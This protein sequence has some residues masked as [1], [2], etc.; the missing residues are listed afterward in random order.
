MDRHNSLRFL[1]EI[2]DQEATP[3]QQHDFDNHMKTCDNCSG[4]YRSEQL[5]NNGMQRKLKQAIPLGPSDT[6]LRT[7]ILSQ[8][9]IEEKAEFQSAVKTQTTPIRRISRIVAVA[10]TFVFLVGAGYFG[11]ELYKH[12]NIYI[13]LERAHWQAADQSASFSNN[14]LTVS[15]MGKFAEQYKYN[16]SSTIGDFQLVGGQ[17]QEIMGV[18]MGHFVFVKNDEIVSVFVVP[19]K[20]FKIPE[21]LIEHSVHKNNTSFFDHNC[22]GCRLV[23]HENNGLVIITATTDK[24]VDLT[25]FVPGERSI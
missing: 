24:G 13:P 18:E 6:Q 16:I 12:Y 15:S 21:E 2:I 14:L 22:R 8:L 1:Y 19:S 17:M 20:D 9:D 25:E 4:I 11:T 10:A 5:L 7:R 3:Q 23:Y